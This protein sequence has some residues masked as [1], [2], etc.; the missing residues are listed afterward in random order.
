[1]TLQTGRF[2]PL[3]L[4]SISTPRAPVRGACCFLTQPLMHAA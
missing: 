3:P 2:P 1:M 4:A